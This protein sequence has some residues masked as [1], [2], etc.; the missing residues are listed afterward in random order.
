MIWH[1]RA[2]L[3]LLLLVPLV[4]WRWLGYKPHQAVRFSSIDWLRRQGAGWRVRARHALP[5]LRTLTIILLVA[6]LARPQ[7]GNEETR[8][9][10]EGIAIQMLVDRSGSMMA[11]D[12]HADGKRVNRLEAV[13]RVFKDFVLG[14]GDLTGRPDDLI[15]MVTFARYADSMSPLTLDHSYLIATLDQTEIVTRNEEDGTAIGDAIALAVERMRDLERRRDVIDFNRIKGKIMILLTDGENNAGDID[16]ERAAELA[17]TFDVKIY[18]IGAGTQGVAPVPMTD[19]F[20]RVVMRPRPVT[21]DE[22]TLKRIARITGGKYYRATDTDSLRQIYREIDEL[23]KTK[24][25]EKRYQQYAELATEWIE[26]D[27]L[28]TPPLLAIV[29][30]LLALEILLANTWLR[31]AP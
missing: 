30:G 15:G 21:I 31:K 19:V 29:L 2:M 18:T 11:M 5:V 6:C 25:E 10:S 7:Q 9:F 16:P 20:G 17:K 24:T 23:E 12:F 27:R 28:T 26:F 8:I 4:W 3:A 14:G 22:A 13:K 1:D